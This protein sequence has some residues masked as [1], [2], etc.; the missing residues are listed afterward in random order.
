MIIGKISENE[1]TVRFKA[2]IHCN[3]CQKQV[4]GGLKTGEKNYQTREFGIELERFLKNYLCGKCR[5]KKRV[6]KN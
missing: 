1:K 5:D 2:D 3:N 6:L 4:S